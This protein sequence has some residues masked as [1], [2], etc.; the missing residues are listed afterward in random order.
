M[1]GI[2]VLKSFHGAPTESDWNASGTV[3]SAK[4]FRD[5][6]GASV[7]FAQRQLLPSGLGMPIPT[8]SS[9][10]L[11]A[12]IIIEFLNSSLLLNLK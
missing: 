6:L 11:T 9:M 8:K 3:Y 10:P 2:T 12:I 5:A 4:I 1:I 7:T